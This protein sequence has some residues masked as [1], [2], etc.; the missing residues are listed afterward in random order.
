MA[1]L[2]VWK[3]T[4]AH[5]GDQRVFFR[6]LLSAATEPAMR[7]TRFKGSGP[8]KFPKIYLTGAA[9]LAAGRNEDGCH[10][11]RG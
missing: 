9:V 1:L 11:F 7:A 4:D 5:R 8:Q 3:E 6:P 10:S 2:R